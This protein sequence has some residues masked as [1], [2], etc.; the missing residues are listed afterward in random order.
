MVEI[1]FKGFENLTNYSN[2]YLSPPEVFS[3]EPFNI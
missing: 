3:Y 1:Q 2:E